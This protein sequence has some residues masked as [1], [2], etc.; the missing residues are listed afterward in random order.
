[1]A[2]P[3]QLTFRNVDAVEAVEAEIRDHARKLELFYSPIMNC[4]VMVDGPAIRQ[5]KGYSFQVRIR[6]TVPGGEIVINRAPTLRPEERKIARAH[7]HRAE[8]ETSRKNIEG[9]IK[10]AFAAARRQLENY[11]RRQRLDVKTH[12]PAAL[13]RVTK[14]IPVKSCGYIETP[15]GREIY[16]HANSVLRGQFKNLKLGSEVRFIEERGEKG[17]QAS[18]VRLVPKVRPAREALPVRAK[19]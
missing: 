6:L 16:F 17:P 11:A 12:E 9:A 13:A 10:Q 18:T 4:R 7:H 15:D 3:V 2:V 1:M 8:M 14:L 5:K 19:R